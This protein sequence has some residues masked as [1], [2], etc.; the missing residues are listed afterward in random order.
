MGSPDVLSAERTAISSA[1]RSASILA[2]APALALQRAIAVS[3][4]LSCA[5]VFAQAAASTPAAAPAPTTYIGCVQ[6]APDSTLVIST[7]SACAKLTGKLA[8]N[9]DALAG[10]QIELQGILTPRTPDAAASIQLKSVVS[11]GKSCT[12]V[13]SLSPP[14]TRGLHRPDSA[15]PG[16]EGGTPGV[17]A[18]PH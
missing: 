14:G 2:T 11:V 12:D 15:I 17:A 3:L 7:P 13:C 16:S 1:K 10:H 8:A 4:C 9:S 6:K 18:P 5:Q